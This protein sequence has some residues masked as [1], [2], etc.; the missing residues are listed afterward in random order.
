MV[1]AVGVASGVVGTGVEEASVV[2][3][4]GVVVVTGAE[5]SNRAGVE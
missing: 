3:D 2:E 1:E 4:G 5:G